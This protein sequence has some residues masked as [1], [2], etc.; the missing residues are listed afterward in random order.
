MVLERDPKTARAAGAAP[1]SPVALALV[2]GVPCAV[3][4]LVIAMFAT[5]AATPGILGDAGPL[6]RWGLPVLRTTGDLA[7]AVVLGSLLLL[8]CALVPASPAWRAVGRLASGA[9]VVWVLAAVVLPV[10]SFADIAG[11]P[12]TTGGLGSQIGF[13]LTQVPPGR[14]LLATAVLAVLAGTVVALGID[15]PTAAAWAAVLT[16]AA[17]VPIALGSHG[18]SEGGHRTVVSGWWLHMLGAGVWVGGLVALAIAG[19]HLQRALPAVV[20]RYSA[21]ALGAYVLVVVSGLANGWVQVGSTASGLLSPYG[22]LLMVKALAAVCLGAVGWWH[23]RSSIAG[24]ERAAAKSDRAATAAAL[25]FWRLV[26]GELLVMAATIG[27]AVALV[28]TGPPASAGGGPRTLAE[29]L[30]SEV[31]PPLPA[32][33]LRLLTEPAPDL[34][35]LLVCGALAL[36]Y[37][38]GLRRLRSRGDRWPVRR[39]LAWFSGLVVL[40]WATSFGPQAYIDLLFSAH[41]VAHM[42][43]MMV[44]PMLLVAGAPITLAMRTLPKRSDGSRGP[45]EWLLVLVH[46]RWARF[47]SHPLVAAVLFAG[48]VIVFYYSPLFGLALS[49]HLG[50]ELMQ[51]HFLLTGYLFASAVIGVDPGAWNPPY[52]LRLLLLLGTMAFH[53]FFGVALTGGNDL[54]AADW[55]SRLGLGVDALADQRTGGAIAWGIG[56]LPTL[57]L[58]I[59]LAVQWSRSDERETRRRDRAADRDGDAE[60]TAYNAMLAARSGGATPRAGKEKE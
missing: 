16:A 40:T 60:L 11:T 42:T 6:V 47:V 1:S 27:V 34:L 50:H 36:A 57:V 25:P 31:V 32:T 38:A 20:R 48:S 13:F 52:P 46:S 35:W 21:L 15:T 26:V 41:M 23:R 4:A 9:A 39:S 2:L 12:L 33:P 29:Q 56:E 18:S 19:P 45:R 24:L 43:I 54:L 55:F 44:A 58:A 7:V 30:T 51:L 5:G 10:F 22:A 53:A 59:V 3:L 28:R 49:T 37:A 17:L 8:A 14:T